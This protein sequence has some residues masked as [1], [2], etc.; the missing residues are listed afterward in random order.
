MKRIFE[1]RRETA[2]AST[3]SGAAFMGRVYVVGRYQAAVEEVL[4]EGGFAI[5]FL[6]KISSGVRCA[7]KR[8]YVNNDHDLMVCQREI[9]IMKELSGHK[10]IVAYLDSSINPQSSSGVSEVLI[11]MEFCRAGQVVNQ[12]NQRLNTGFNEAEVLQIFCETCEAVACLHQA[13]TP[14]IHRDLKVENILLHDNGNY[15]LCDFGSATNQ[16]LNPQV[17]GVAYVE[18]EIK[19][20]TTLSYRAPEMINLHEGKAITTKADIWALGCLLYKLCFFTL[21]FGESQVAIC[22]GSFTVPDHSR[23]SNGMHCL[24][25]YM[26]E[27]DQEK[28]PDIYQVSHFAFKFTGRDCPVANVHGA[29]LPATLPEPL[30]ASEA[31]ARKTQAK[32]KLTDAIGPTET[33]IVPRQRPKAGQSNASAGVAMLP[34]QAV[35]STPRKRPATNATP[36]PTLNSQA[37]VPQAGGN[38]VHT[39][40]AAPQHEPFQNPPSAPLN[41]PQGT[42][43]HYPVQQ[44]LQQFVQPQR[45]HQVHSQQQIQLQQ[46]FLQQQQVQA[47]F[48]AINPQQQQQ[49]L[50]QQQQLQYM[51]QVV[52]MQHSAQQPTQ[53]PP[54]PTV[55]VTPLTSP[56]KQR[57]QGH[58]RI[59][60]DVTHSSVF[61]VS[62]SRSTQQMAA[63]AAYASLNKSKSASTTPSG[64]PHSSQHDIRLTGLPPPDLSTWN[65]FGDDFSPPS[66]P[67]QQGSLA[68]MPEDSL[69]PGL[70][71]PQTRPL[72]QMDIFGA[73]PFIAKP[74]L[75]ALCPTSACTRPGSL[76][77]EKLIQGLKTPE[78][79]LLLS[80]ILLPADPFASPSNGLPA[81]VGVRCDD[82]VSESKESEFDPIPL[83][84]RKNSPNHSR[85]SSEGSADGGLST[86]G[87][88]SKSALHLQQQAKIRQSHTA[89]PETRTSRP[90]P[91]VSPLAL[92][93]PHATSLEKVK[94]KWSSIEDLSTSSTTSHTLA[95]PLTKMDHF[96]EQERQ[97]IPR[98]A[99]NDETLTQVVTST[100][101]SIPAE[102][103]SAT[104]RGHP[105][106]VYACSQSITAHNDDTEES[107]TLNVDVHNESHAFASKAA[108]S[109]EE[110]DVFSMAP[111]PKA[112]NNSTRDKSDIFNQAPFIKKSTSFV[113]DTCG[114]RASMDTE[115]SK[116]ECLPLRE[117]ELIKPLPATSDSAFVAC[118]LT[119]DQRQSV[120]GNSAFLA[121]VSPRPFNSRSL[122]QYSRHFRRSRDGDNSQ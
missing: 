103:Q 36:P 122:P 16:V 83:P 52:A 14:Y 121:V 39:Q 43:Q 82:E 50:L 62:A 19:K 40:P 117:E 34:L 15:V 63:A 30:K 69:I 97:L 68:Q 42:Q 70:K 66:G 45:F 80:D 49:Q 12:M 77:P 51:Q 119:N 113:S 25:C 76:I 48:Q 20:Y 55:T 65:P 111:F 104:D 95:P 59:V 78:I 24:I 94:P 10:N 71:P 13:K 29:V 114:S 101:H 98:Q 89:S 67:E 21:P 64:S 107:V 6:V 74:G 32:T 88:N 60:S 47:Q 44:P 58:R 90:S 72:T 9:A 120:K 56:T 38:Q 31:A 54:A 2:S 35:A 85:N 17:L 79:P 8:M 23:Y 26:L 4:A 100:A 106:G 109:Q 93:K 75:A 18:E 27:P 105:S 84:A 3:T 57:P 86:L 73:V 28:R 11:L 5:V 91:S 61:G 118:E 110:L 7:L 102:L 37:M 87:S 46:A 53:A 96:E 108:S 81:D 92:S 1:G 41:Y 22:D 112:T 116:K 115:Q 99:A 33:S